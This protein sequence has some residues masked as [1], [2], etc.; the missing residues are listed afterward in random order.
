MFRDIHLV[1]NKFYI[2]IT[3]SHLYGHQ[4]DKFLLEDL[5]LLEIISVERNIRDK[6]DLH[7][8]VRKKSTITPG[9]P[10]DPT[11]CIIEVTKVTDLVGEIIRKKNIH[12]KISSFLYDIGLLQANA[13]DQVYWVGF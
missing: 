11:V 12:K 1:R 2:T 7:D 4:Y 5:P 8:N 9:L 10:H 3:L 6:S 13:F